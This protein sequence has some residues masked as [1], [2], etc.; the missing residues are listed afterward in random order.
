VYWHIYYL[1]LDKIFTEKIDTKCT[2]RREVEVIRTNE[3]IMC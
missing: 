2:T 1:L 3:W